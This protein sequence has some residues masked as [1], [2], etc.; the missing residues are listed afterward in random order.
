M[1]SIAVQPE[2]DSESMMKFALGVEGGVHV[3]NLR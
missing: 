1:G 3:R 2:T